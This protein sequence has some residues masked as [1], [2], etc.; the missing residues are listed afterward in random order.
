[1]K[2]SKIAREHAEVTNQQGLLA[3]R[4]SSTFAPSLPPIPGHALYEQPPFESLPGDGLVHLQDPALDII[5][6]AGGRGARCLAGE[7]L[8]GRPSRR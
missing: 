8:P 2:T 3:R 4:P 6:L 7:T 5:D 1:M